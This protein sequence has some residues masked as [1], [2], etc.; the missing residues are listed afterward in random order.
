MPLFRQHDLPF[1]TAWSDLAE[2]T[3]ARGVAIVGTPG[4]IATITTKDKTY[5]AHQYVRANGARRQEIIG[6]ADD[7]AT[8]ALVEELQSKIT[9]AKDLIEQIRVLA[10]LG[11][12]TAD[13]KTYYIAAALSNAGLFEKGITLIGSH[14]YGVILNTLGIYA[15]AYTSHDVDLTR[16]EPIAAPR[17]DIL[18]LLKGTGIEFIPVPAFKH[19]DPS[20]S[21][22]ELGKSRFQVDLLVPSK[23][24]DI[25]VVNMP[26]LRTHAMALPYLD[27]LLQDTQQGVLAS[28][29]G[30]VVARVPS[31]ARF[32]IHKLLSSR[33]RVNTHDKI[34]KD[35]EQASV[36]LAALSVLR[37]TEIETATA[38][39]S[40]SGRDLLSK[41]LPLI[42]QRLA[43]E[44][45]AVF[46]EINSGL[47]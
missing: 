17:V 20:T 37:P 21:Y 6:S 39:L 36:L 10:K 14:A 18:E 25:R 28:R 11:Y 47:G 41:A 35:L 29:H 1:Q 44:H 24:E 19:N 22:K 45:P 38:E 3:R 31:P 30:A 8:A 42:E 13:S 34:A 32:A 26:D 23:D 43:D 12:Q 16:S 7:P 2:S 33:L 27:F 40:P 5:F 4:G 9:A 15:P 46:D